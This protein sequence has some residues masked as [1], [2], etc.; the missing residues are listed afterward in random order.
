MMKTVRTSE[1]SVFFNECTRRC[2]PEGC[3]LPTVQLGEL[4]RVLT[5]ERLE[6]YMRIATREIIP[7]I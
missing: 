2:M 5:Y 3:N 6:G 7:V 1:T 4:G